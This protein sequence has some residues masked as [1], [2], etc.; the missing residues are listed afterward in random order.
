MLELLTLQDVPAL[1][2]LHGRPLAQSPAEKHQNYVL[3][4]LLS[5]TRCCGLS[6]FPQPPTK[7][8][9]SLFRLFTSTSTLDAWAD[10]QSAKIRTS[11]TQTP[12]PTS[13]PKS[14]LF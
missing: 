9:Q 3:D 4:H 11:K 6:L 8:A 7:L 14:G 1:Q 5:S 2:L 10:V 13:S 12:R